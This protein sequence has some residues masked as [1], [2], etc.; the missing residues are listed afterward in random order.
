MFKRTLI[1]VSLLCFLFTLAGA[2]LAQEAAKETKK[3]DVV[4]HEYVGANKCKICHKKD[5][6]HPS[7]SETL[8]AKAWESLKPENQKNKECVACH[9]TG[10]TAEGE[11]LEG[12]QC[13]VCHGPGS[14]Y[15]KKSIMEDRELAIANGLLIPDEKT[16]LKCHNE[17]VPEEFRSKEKFDFE[18]MKTKGV[19]AMAAKEEAKETTKTE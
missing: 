3:T 17:K 12:V 7:W 1:A 8:H 16:C 5:G 4:K 14:D 11:I 13:E 19:H 2:S 15:K 9:S 10:T 18:K 6:I